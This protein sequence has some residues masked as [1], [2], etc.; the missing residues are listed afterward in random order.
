MNAVAKDVARQEHSLGSDVGVDVGD[1]VAHEVLQVLGGDGD[2][3]VADV[4]LL[5]AVL[6]V[7]CHGSPLVALCGCSVL[8]LRP[9]NADQE[10]APLRPTAQL[11]SHHT[12]FP[13]GLLLLLQ[14]RPTLRRLLLYLKA[15]D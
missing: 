5:D 4:H 3:L 9:M 1:S 10:V 14:Q 8:L 12:D 15:D 7:G 13:P 2:V 6:L 11:T